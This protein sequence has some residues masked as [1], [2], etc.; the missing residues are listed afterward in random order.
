MNRQ[1]IRRVQP[2]R[3]NFYSLSISVRRST[4]FRQVFRP[5]SG[6][7]NCTILVWQI[8]D[9]DDGRKT[10]LKHIERLTEINKSWNVATCWLYSA[11]IY[12]LCQKLIFVRKNLC[13]TN[14]CSW[15][16]AMQS[17]SIILARHCR[18]DLFLFFL[19]TDIPRYCVIRTQ[20]WS[21]EEIGVLYG[22]TLRQWCCCHDSHAPGCKTV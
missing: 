1:Y 8:P 7:Q 11:N 12:P 18:F 5:S 9:S 21:K 6:S 13:D 14:L 17:E 16:H 19:L 2:K 15:I 3:C 10:R 20:F 22:I 4:C